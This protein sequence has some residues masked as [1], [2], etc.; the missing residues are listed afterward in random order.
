MIAVLITLPTANT[1]YNVL[2]RVKAAMT[3]ANFN[4]DH[5]PGRCT[6]ITIQYITNTGQAFIVPY[7]GPYTDTA[8]VPPQY[9]YSFQNSGAYFDKNATV[10][11][12]SLGEI[13]LSSD[14]AEAQ[15]AIL[16]IAA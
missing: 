16:A 10:N 6:S 1:G 15:F 5:L 14:Q 3:A 2:E 11:N 12:L 13:N 8:G 7:I 4:S 9:G